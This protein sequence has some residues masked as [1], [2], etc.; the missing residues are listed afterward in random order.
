MEFVV[1][2]TLPTQLAS[3]FA[4][5]SSVSVVQRVTGRALFARI[6]APA[7]DFVRDRNANASP[8]L[9]MWIAL[10][11]LRSRVALTTAQGMADVAKSIPNSNAFVSKASPETPAFLSAQHVRTTAAAKGNA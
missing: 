7:M 10:V 8:G 3:G 9:P 2:S 5:V 1:H 4:L 6:I 11:L